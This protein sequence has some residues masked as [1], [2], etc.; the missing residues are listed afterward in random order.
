MPFFRYCISDLE[1]S[2][3]EKNAVNAPEN[4]PLKQTY[5]GRQSVYKDP[6]E[7]SNVSPGN[8]LLDYTQVINNDFP[9]S[10]L[11]SKTSPELLHYI[12]NDPDPL[13][14]FMN[15]PKSSFQSNN[16]GT[17]TNYH[18]PAASNMYLYQKK[19]LL[20]ESESSS[21]SSLSIPEGLTASERELYLQHAT[22]SQILDSSHNE[23]YQS[24]EEQ[25]VQDDDDDV[26]D[27]LFL[28]TGHIDF[29]TH[30][31]SRPGSAN[32]LEYSSGLGQE[33]SRGT[34]RNCPK[35][36]VEKRSVSFD[37]LPQEQSFNPNEE[38]PSFDHD[39]MTISLPDNL[40]DKNAFFN[41]K[42][43]QD[44]CYE[45]NQCHPDFDKNISERHSGQLQETKNVSNSFFNEDISVNYDSNLINGKSL[46]RSEALKSSYTQYSSDEKFQ[47]FHN[48]KISAIPEDLS[49]QSK[50]VN[51]K[52]MEE[53][54]K[55]QKEIETTMN[56]LENSGHSEVEE[57]SLS[58]S[59]MDDSVKSFRAK[60][61]STTNISSSLTPIKSKY[62][63]LSEL[64]NIPTDGDDSIKNLNAKLE[65]ELS[66]R[67]KATQLVEQLQNRYDNLL[68]RYAD[69]EMMIDELRIG[70]KMAPKIPDFKSS[71]SP[72]TNLIMNR[73]LVTS[74]PMASTFSMNQSLRDG[75]DCLIFF[76]IFK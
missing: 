30:Q 52:N 76:L 10:P 8:Q 54:E 27:E 36:R 20:A 69:A 2:D 50:F 22:I 46:V 65:E 7:I 43:S 58:K 72:I 4:V 75:K 26:D 18:T 74:T 21:K 64:S 31:S 45:T 35:S 41:Q 49:G 15:Q 33:M 70:S 66:K 61:K 13:E 56:K 6:V 59:K 3:D 57:G 67:K 60:S 17:V 42:R 24:E 32:V 38:I 5:I 55:H 51:Q 9:N 62:K 23:N 1:I 25:Q 14:V 37:L 16:N 63:S 19:D 12:Y 39:S 11:N 53:M 28:I 48:Q 34:E 40:Q 47:V 71:Q 29:G 73:A 68:T 44:P